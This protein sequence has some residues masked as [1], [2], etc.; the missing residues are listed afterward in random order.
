MPKDNFKNYKRL[1]H[2]VY[3]CRYH[4]VFVTKYRF[5]I[6][7]KDIEVA[8]KWAIKDVCD[9]KDTE[10]LEGEVKEEHV[11]LYLQIPPKYSVSDIVKWIK[12]KR[13]E[14]LLKRYPELKKQ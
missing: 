4:L 9:W 5:K 11:H 13:A 10:I 1:T 3:D 8:L 14:R 6:I 7:N 12:G 2:A